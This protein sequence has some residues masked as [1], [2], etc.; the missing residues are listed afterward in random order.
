MG[1]IA[2]FD[3]SFLQSLSLD[4]SVWFDQFYIPN[5][6]PL[7][8]V[9]TLADLDKE[10]SRGRTAE[11]VVGNIAEKSPQLSG[12][13][14]V[15]HSELLLANLLGQPVPMTNRPIVAGGRSVE[16]GGRK[17]V[18]IDISPE[19][20]AF[21][22]WQDGEYQQIER[23]FAKVWRTN[24]KSMSFEGSANYAQKLGIDISLCKNIQDAF[25]S[26]SQIVTNSG[27]PYDLI[28]FIVQT[29][30]IPREYHHEFVKRY[31]VSGF[32]PLIHY[33]PYAAHV[34]KVEVF[35]HI[36]VT[37]GF[38]SAARPSNKIDI[39]YLHYLPFCNV[40][41][42]GDKLHRSTANLFLGKRQRFV[43][44]PDLKEDLNKLNDY[45]LK[46]PQETKDRGVISFASKPPTE[47]KFLTAELWD[48]LGTSW[49][50][51]SENI[52]PVSEE[53]NEKLLRHIKAFTDAPTLPADQMPGPTEELDS[54]SIQRSIR[55]KRG[56]WYQV[57][58]DLK[59]G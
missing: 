4:E 49:R 37:R 35:F 16:S 59:D 12:A 24:I 15:H 42:S 10:M 28:A 14:N 58:K 41:V 52:A 3:K 5:I 40:F 11:Q 22:R 34:I 26:A 50:T 19:A 9:E 48:M 45:Y 54:L 20:K 44:G 6:S 21:N 39:A 32:P 57:P 18:N 27:K 17:G 1:P 47:E 53:A 31:Q 33:A 25:A 55:R 46:L 23:D 30:G 7:F 13:P 29:L 56:S 43:W 38:I 2:L 51:E 36:C 8:Y